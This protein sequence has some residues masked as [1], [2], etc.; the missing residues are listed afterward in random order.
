M[1]LRLFLQ[2]RDPSTPLDPS[3]H[4]HPHPHP[5]RSLAAPTQFNPINPHPP[6]YSYPTDRVVSLLN[7]VCPRSESSPACLSPPILNP[8]HPG[9]ACLL[10]RPRS[11]VCLTFPFL[12]SL[13]S[14]FPCSHRPDPICTT[15]I[16]QPIF[17]SYP[18]Q[19][20]PPPACP[21]SLSSSPS[22]VPC[23]ASL[24]FVP[25]R[26]KP[27][28]SSSPLFLC[29]LHSL[30]HTLQ[31]VRHVFKLTIRPC[32]N[33]FPLNLH[34]R[35]FRHVE[36]ATNSSHLFHPPPSCALVTLTYL[37]CPSLFVHCRCPAQ[38]GCTSIRYLRSPH[39]ILICASI[40]SKWSRASRV[41]PPLPSRPSSPSFMYE[42][43]ADASCCLNHT[44]TLSV[45][46][47]LGTH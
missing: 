44:E 14:H 33:G 35:C 27:S 43:H 6:A 47:K 17:L 28:L 30:P 19:R 10:Y 3:T 23:V 24:Y 12:A 42:T 22:L 8:F 18:R 36:P 5:T 21:P 34:P 29:P 41:D 11:H 1:P 31:L 26:S 4:P 20:A 40:I 46:Q 15:R 2:N 7:F 38:F 9:L 13:T 32:L 39:G 25:S 37:L 16:R 45:R